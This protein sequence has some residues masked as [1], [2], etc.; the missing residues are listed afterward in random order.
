MA[1]K[2]QEHGG[3]W[4]GGLNG[5]KNVELRK[6]GC[7]VLEQHRP[8]G[9]RLRPPSLPRS[10]SKA[11]PL[12]VV[13]KGNC[14][15]EEGGCKLIPALLIDSLEAWILYFAREKWQLIQHYPLSFCLPVL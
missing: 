14:S 2:G 12:P 13:T 4:A 5:G 6:S 15:G 7:L 11:T 9:Q 8:A 10:R 1:G 3:D